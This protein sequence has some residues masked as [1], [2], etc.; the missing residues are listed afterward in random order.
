MNLT[1]HIGGLLSVQTTPGGNVLNDFTGLSLGDMQEYSFNG[2]A[3]HLSDPTPLSSAIKKQQNTS[4][5]GQ[6]MFV[7]QGT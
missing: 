5:S 7:N 3:S 6:Q 4:P 2:P 1:A